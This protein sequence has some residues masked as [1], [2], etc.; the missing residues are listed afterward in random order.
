[1][2]C[3][4]KFDLIIAFYKWQMQAI[5]VCAS[6]QRSARWIKSTPGGVNE[7]DNNEVLKESQ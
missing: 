2:N 1:M 4:I 5:V 6:Y 7:V 3:H